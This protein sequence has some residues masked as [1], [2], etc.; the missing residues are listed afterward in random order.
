MAEKEEVRREDTPIP[1][2][3]AQGNVW[4]KQVC[5]ALR[6]SLA[7][8]CVPTRTATARLT[9]PPTRFAF[10]NLWTLL[11]AVPV[12]FFVQNAKEDKE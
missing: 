9:M 7:I 12:F 2:P 8:R 6:K 1:V 3:N 11:V 10:A 4:Q 5:P